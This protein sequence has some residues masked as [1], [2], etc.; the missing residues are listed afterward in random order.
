[1]QTILINY[2]L[3]NI[4]NNSYKLLSENYWKHLW[5]TTTRE[6]IANNLN[7]L[8]GIISN[9]IHTY[10]LLSERSFHSYK[11]LQGKSLQTVLTNYYQRIIPNNNYKLLPKK[12]LQTYAYKMLSEN[13]I[14]SKQYFLFIAHNT[15][16]LKLLSVNSLQKMLSNLVWIL[17]QVKSRVILLTKAQISV[18]LT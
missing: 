5:Q 2:H 4:S 9:N 18:Q 6:I 12:S 3:R 17:Q 11:L 16:V 7:N 15:I 10:I 14:H 1:M 8:L 13:S